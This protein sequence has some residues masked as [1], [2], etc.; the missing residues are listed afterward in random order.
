M[1][2]LSGKIGS[3]ELISKCK[4]VSERESR[5]TTTSVAWA[6]GK[7]DILRWGIQKKN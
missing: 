2:D 5:R 7:K 4:R 3:E 6:T 1:R